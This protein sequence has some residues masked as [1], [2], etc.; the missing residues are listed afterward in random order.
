MNGSSTRKLQCV[1]RQIHYNDMQLCKNGMQYASNSTLGT[2]GAVGNL[3]SHR[4]LSPLERL[5]TRNW[6]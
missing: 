6:I 4:L 2:F 3:T 1:C 5:Q